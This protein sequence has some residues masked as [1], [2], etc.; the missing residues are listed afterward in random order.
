MG[1]NGS[2]PTTA[3]G[4]GVGNQQALDEG[5]LTNEEDLLV[6][7][8][9]TTHALRTD[10]RLRSVPPYLSHSS[11]KPGQLIL[12]G[13]KRALPPDPS[14]AGAPTT[15]NGFANPSHDGGGNRSAPT[16]TR[17]P[18]A[19]LANRPSGRRVLMAN[20]F[21]TGTTKSIYFKCSK[22]G[23]LEIR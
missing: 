8:A 4:P 13:R 21:A 22:F 14:R 15:T 23:L 19:K 17:K 3:V 5:H 1:P 20:G 18:L 6:R 10:S 16:P 9:V 2:K 12:M 11:Q 7:S